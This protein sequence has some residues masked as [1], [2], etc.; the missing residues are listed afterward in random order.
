MKAKKRHRVR[1]Y[2]AR[3]NHSLWSNS[4]AFALN[5]SGSIKETRTTVAEIMILS[6]LNFSSHSQLLI[7]KVSFRMNQIK[8]PSEKSGPEDTFRYMARIFNQLRAVEEKESI[9]K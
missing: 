9:D 2:L 1:G 6:A 3:R 8:P 5:E 4:A 7:I